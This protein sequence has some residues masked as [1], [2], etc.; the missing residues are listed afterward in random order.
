[1]DY[2]LGL[3]RWSLWVTAALLCMAVSGIGVVS[4]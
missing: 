1:M 2:V 3:L 4:F